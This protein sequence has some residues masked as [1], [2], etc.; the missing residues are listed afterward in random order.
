MAMA[1][2]WLGDRDNGSSGREARARRRREC[3]RRRA[4]RQA[5][6]PRRTASPKRAEQSRTASR[7]LVSSRLVSPL[8][9]N[10][11]EAT[12]IQYVPHA[13]CRAR[14]ALSASVVVQRLRTWEFEWAASTTIVFSLCTRTRLVHVHRARIGPLLRFVQHIVQY[15]YRLQENREKE[16]KN[17]SK[18]L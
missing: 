16:R 4:G 9:S 3:R 17:T 11:Q 8:D 14:A 6:A 13:S 5:T 2:E 7:R 1:I 12:F 15:M 10:R 18:C